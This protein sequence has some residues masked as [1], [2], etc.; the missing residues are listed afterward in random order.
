MKSF[1]ILRGTLAGIAVAFLQFGTATAGQIATPIL[2]LS[3]NT[4]QVFCTANNVS[5]SSVTV[6][7]TIRGVVS[8]SAT[9][10]CTLPANDRGGCQVVL[11]GAGQCRI[12]VTGLT[13][14][15]VADR[16]RGVMITRSTAPPFAIEAVVQAQ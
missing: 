1:N 3:N 2:F 7:V 9:D 10:T 15:Q 5:A 16:V 13:N 4:N 12:S 11:A 6:R 14:A 8:G